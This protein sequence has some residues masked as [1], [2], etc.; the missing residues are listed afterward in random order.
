[1]TIQC[2]AVIKKWGNS[3]AIIVPKDSIESEHMKENDKVALLIQKKDNTLRK[4]FGMLKGKFKRTAQQI[5]DDL[6][7][8]SYD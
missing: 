1:M 8:E 7:A 6:R 2:E 5:K 3:F 4:S